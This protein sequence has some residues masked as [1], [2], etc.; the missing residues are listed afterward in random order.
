MAENR[1]AFPS[2]ESPSRGK[3]CKNEK[4]RL[5]VSQP[6]SWLPGALVPRGSRKGYMLAGMAASLQTP[7]LNTTLTLGSSEGTVEHS[8]FL[9]WGGCTSSQLPCQWHYGNGN[10][11][12][13]SM[14]RLDFLWP[15]ASPISVSG[16]WL[17][18]QRGTA[19]TMSGSPFLAHPG[20]VL[21]RT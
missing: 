1:I 7:W 2:S 17:G 8:S 4:E 13:L 19:E 15:D 20:C 16:V 10:G 5:A 11:W 18:L 6:C 9:C 14:Y 3:V 21:S 12:L